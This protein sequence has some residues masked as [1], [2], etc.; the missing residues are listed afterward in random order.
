VTRNGAFRRKYLGTKYFFVDEKM[1]AFQGAPGAVKILAARSTQIYLQAYDEKRQ[2]FFS[3]LGADP[4]KMVRRT[5]VACS[6][7]VPETID[8]LVCYRDV[9]AA[10]AKSVFT[11]LYT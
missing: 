11:K 2:I 7:M 4:P 3:L 6:G 5:L 9:P 10:I 1:Q 8:G